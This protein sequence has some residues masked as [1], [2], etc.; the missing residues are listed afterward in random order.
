MDINTINPVLF[1]YIVPKILYLYLKNDTITKNIFTLILFVPVIIYIYIGFFHIPASLIYAMIHFALPGSGYV[2]NNHV[3]TFLILTITILSD[4]ATDLAIKKS[5]DPP[6][7]FLETQFAHIVVYPLI[8]L[9][10]CF[11]FI[12]IFILSQ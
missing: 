5:S 3:E 7:G 2:I 8:A 10:F 4:M 1:L 6:K 12:I 9:A 11:P